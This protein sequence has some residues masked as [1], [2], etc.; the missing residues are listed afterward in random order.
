MKKL[1]KRWFVFSGLAFQIGATMY[2][3]VELGGWIENKISSQNNFPTF[4][5]SLIGLFGVIYIVFK[6]SKNF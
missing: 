6:Q 1:P 2:L 5:C 4:I 3:M